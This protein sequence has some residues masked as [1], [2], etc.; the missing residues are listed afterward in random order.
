MREEPSF[1]RKCSEFFQGF[2]GDVQTSAGHLMIVLSVSIHVSNSWFKSLSISQQNQ[3]WLV[4]IK[5]RLVQDVFDS[6][7]L[8]VAHSLSSLSL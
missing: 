2:V 3:K 7:C 8:V 1:D 6:L 4:F 5:H